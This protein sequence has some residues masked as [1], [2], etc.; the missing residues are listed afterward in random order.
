M[1]T[2]CGKDGW[3]MVPFRIQVIKPS[4]EIRVWLICPHCKN[5]VVDTYT[6]PVG[7]LKGMAE[8]EVQIEE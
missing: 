6:Y 1:I 5:V 8:I 4:C 7:G 2:T 3:Q